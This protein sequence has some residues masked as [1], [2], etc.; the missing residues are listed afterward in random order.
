[1]EGSRREITYK[2]NERFLRRHVYNRDELFFNL[3]QM[4]SQL[5]NPDPMSEVDFRTN[6]YF[7]K[8]PNYTYEKYVIDAVETMEIT[9]DYG[10]M[11][12]A[13]LSGMVVFSREAVDLCEFAYVVP[14]LFE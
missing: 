4:V 3:E 8:Y 7:S 2:Q 12:V 9:K 13:A 14:C 1:M 6:F 10:L 5:V 11:L